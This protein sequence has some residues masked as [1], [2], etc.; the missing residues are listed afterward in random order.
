MGDGARPADDTHE[1]SAPSTVGTW[2]E[3]ADGYRFQETLHGPNV[4][5]RCVDCGGRCYAIP[6]CATARCEPCA[7]RRVGATHAP[8]SQRSG[9]PPRYLSQGPSLA[10]TRAQEY[11]RSRGS[12]E[13]S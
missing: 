6:D 13:D 12:V 1:R 8:F 4:E 3:F 10:E 5:H 11:H 9:G 7:R 2:H